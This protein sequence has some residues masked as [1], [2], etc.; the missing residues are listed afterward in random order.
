M[1]KTL[2]ILTPGF[3]ADENDSTCLPPVQQFIQHFKEANPLLRIVII[4]IAYPFGHK[5]YIWHNCAVIPLCGNR[6]RKLLRPLLWLKIRNNLHHIKR[7]SHII[8]IL[9][10]WCGEWAMIGTRFGKKYGIPHY[11]W[12]QGQDS[13]AGN[14]YAR[15]FI[16]KQAELIALSDSLADE[17]YKNYQTM[18]ARVVPFG[19]KPVYSTVTQRHIDVIGVGGLIPLKQYHV[20]IR[21]IH[22]LKKIIPGI[23]AVLCGKGTEMKALQQMVNRLELEKNIQFTGEKPHPEVLALL[24]QSKILLHPSSF[25]GFSTVCTEALLC[26]CHAISFCR[27]M[28][29]HISHWHIVPDEEAMYTQVLGLLQNPNTVYEPVVPFVISESIGTI[30]NLLHYSEPN[31]R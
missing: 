3:P 21:V 29:R 15:Y 18:P 23:Q 31:A 19:I 13:R 5:K 28:H 16:N 24:Q 6:Y 7:S 4:A 25:E 9:S 12:L 17:F 26:G 2:V 22:R 20:F 27:A 11:C 30:A 1:D 14:K 8:G 10:F